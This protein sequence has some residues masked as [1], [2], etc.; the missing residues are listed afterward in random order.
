MN[1]S[2]P[3]DRPAVLALL[4]LAARVEER[5]EKALEG[6]GLSIARLKV[7][8]DLVESGPLP[9]SALASR[10][11]CV[12]SNI[13]QLVDRLEADG[14]VRRVADPTDRRSVRAQL[15]E[16]GRARQVRG[17]ARLAATEEEIMARFSAEERAALSSL[18]QALG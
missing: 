12:R 18:F 1:K 7:L 8:N 14:L 10:Q 3:P 16:K 11:N 2:A 15:T 17:Q 6:E 9:L 5:L 13:T 4:R